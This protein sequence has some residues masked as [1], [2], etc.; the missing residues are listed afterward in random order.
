[1]KKLLYF[2]VLLIL[3][4]N[5]F[6]QEANQLPAK[7]WKDIVEIFNNQNNLTSIWDTDIYVSLEG[8]YTKNDSITIDQILK[9][10]NTLTETISI[11]FSKSEQPNFKIKC[12]DTALKEGNGYIIKLMNQIQI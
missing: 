10:L 9:K 6:S 3:G 5:C 8:N 2:L 4:T 1:M 11:Q 7:P 12:L